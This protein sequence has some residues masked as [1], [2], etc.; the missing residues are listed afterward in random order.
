MIILEQ[1]MTVRELQETAKNLFGEMIKAVVD[2]RL[3]LLAIDAEMHSD[4]EALLLDNGS[5]QADLWG[6]NFY[7]FLERDDFLEF[8]SMINMRPSQGNMSRGVEDKVIRD[9][10]VEL[11][12]RWISR[13]DK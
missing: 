4:L 9:S 2:I 7:P 10:I 1:P 11:V 12:D 13:D 6:I 3:G 8:D 5:A